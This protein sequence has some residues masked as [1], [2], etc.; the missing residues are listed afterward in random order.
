M[1]FRLH[2]ALL[3]SHTMRFHAWLLEVLPRSNV[4]LGTM[5]RCTLQPRNVWLLRTL[6]LT[7]HCLKQRLMGPGTSM[8]LYFWLLLP[9]TLLLRRTL[10]LKRFLLWL[11]VCTLQLHAWLLMLYLT[12]SFRNARLH[13]SCLHPLRL[14]K[15][16]R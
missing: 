5:L 10:H 14:Q 16:D 8:R 15:L 1:Y 7:T 9:R 3:L 13:S 4:S 12:P 6:M 2:E 11:V